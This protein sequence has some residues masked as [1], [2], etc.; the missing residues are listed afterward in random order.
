MTRSSTVSLLIFVVCALLL[1]SRCDVLLQGIPGGKR[2]LVLYEDSLLPHTHSLFFNSLKERGHK[3]TF[4]D[5]ESDVITLEKYGEY[6]FDNIMFFCPGVDDFPAF[7]TTDI[8]KFVEQGGNV[9]VTSDAKVSKAVREIGGYSGIKFYSEES[10]VV[11]HF[12]FDKDL[13][14]G[15]HTVIQATEVIDNPFILGSASKGKGEQSPILFY[16]TGHSF[17]PDNILAVEILSANPSSVIIKPSSSSNLQPTIEGAGKSVM[18]VSG[19]QARNNARLTFAGSLDMFSD[20]FFIASVSKNQQSGNMKFCVEL[21]KWAL[22]ERGVLRASQIK[23]SKVDGSLPEVLLKEKERPDLPVSLY[24]DPEIARQSLG[25]RINDDVIYQLLIEEYDGNQW[26]PFIADD[27]Q[28]EFIMLDPYIRKT[29]STN[30]DGI[31]FTSFKVPDVYGIFKF[32]IM[33]RRRGLS[34]LLC[35][36]QVSVRPFKHN[37]YERFIFSAYPYYL[38]AFSMMTGFFIFSFFFLFSRPNKK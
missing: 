30:G 24:P 38:S 5:A 20:K 35:S 10:I 25:Y 7:K 29:M 21:T 14:L 36:T 4:I 33:Y 9:F 32:R 1:P 37:E 8:M 6:L 3:L 34:T 12:L 19:I 15:S 16:G 31:F 27:V 23:H 2:T 18:L 11:D 13:D 26:K 28:I 17:E 22:N